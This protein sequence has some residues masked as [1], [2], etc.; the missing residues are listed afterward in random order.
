MFSCVF[1]DGAELIREKPQFQDQIEPRLQELEGQWET[2]EGT[3]QDK[4]KNLFDANRHIIYEQ[5][6]DDID[7]WITELESQII[8]EDTG[9]DLTTVNLL[10]QK[11]N[12]S[13]KLQ[14]F[15]TS[16]KIIL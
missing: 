7:G 5:S 13:F 8:T 12:V 9:R 11:Q 1:Q 3:T 15:I 14:N 2:L 4:S 16:F 6:V 10:M